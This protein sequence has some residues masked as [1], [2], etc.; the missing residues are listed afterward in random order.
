MQQAFCTSRLNQPVIANEQDVEGNGMGVG[1]RK[2]DP[3]SLV[4]SSA[5]MQ[6]TLH[7]STAVLYFM[8]WPPGQARD[9]L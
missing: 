6:P 2:G 5:M 4:R 9:C 8:P 1:V 3:T 7:M